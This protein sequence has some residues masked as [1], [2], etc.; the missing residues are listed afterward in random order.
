[1]NLSDLR[2][3]NGVARHPTLAAAAAELHLTPS[4]ISKALRRLEADMN[5]KLFDRSGKQL[6]L[7]AN[8]RRML[9]FSREIL[10]LASQAKADIKGEHALIEC[11]VAGPAVLLWRYASRLNG[12]LQ[13]YKESTLSIKTMF[14]DDA[15]AALMRGEVNYAI[16]TSEVIHGRSKYWQASWC[17]TALGSMEMQLVAAPSH[18]LVAKLRANVADRDRIE[19]EMNNT[20]SGLLYSES[21]AVLS[22]DFVSPSHSL[23]CGEQRGSRSDGWRDDQLPRRIRYWIDDLHLLLQMVRSGK[24]LAYLPDF[25][26]SDHGFLR[27]VVSDCTFLCNEQVWLIADGKNA[28][29]WQLELSHYLR[30]CH[31]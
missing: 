29:F 15:L 31:D 13:N 1:M 30:T 6:L 16:V 24:A 8:G 9:D 5:T 19:D 20:G 7:N 28:P 2:I 4:A 27:L 14:E 21:A 18:P 26:V 10:S 23:F 3:F 11:R 12:F 17:A 22:Y 25:A